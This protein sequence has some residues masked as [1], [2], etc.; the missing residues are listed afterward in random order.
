MYTPAWG[1]VLERDIQIKPKDGASI[2]C[3]IEIVNEV[4]TDDISQSGSNEGLAIKID[5][6]FPIVSP[7]Q[8][9]E[10]CP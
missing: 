10:T 5:S 1:N 7:F 8:C 4:H 2:K 3:D 9:F 6:S